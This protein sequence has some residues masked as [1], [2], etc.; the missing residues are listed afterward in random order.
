MNFTPELTALQ[1]VMISADN[2]NSFSKLTAK[3]GNEDEIEEVVLCVKNFL[4]KEKAPMLAMIAQV[5]EVVRWKIHT[6][7]TLGPSCLELAIKLQKL[8]MDTYKN[9]IPEK[10]SS[11]LKSKLKDR[12]PLNM[13]YYRTLWN[14][15]GETYFE[16]LTGIPMQ[17]EILVDKLAFH[18]SQ[19]LPSTILD[20]WYQLW[21]S[22]GLDNDAK[23]NIFHGALF[24]ISAAEKDN[25]TVITWA[26][27]LHCYRN[28]ILLTRHK[29][30]AEPLSNNQVS[31]M[32]NKIAVVAN[33]L[34][35][36]CIEEFQLL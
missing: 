32:I 18:L 16:I 12:N 36:G 10:E 34:E 25:R 20:E 26:C 14:P 21:E 31:T 23:L 11:W 35:E 33:S 22:F 27:L 6:F 5:L 30:V 29:Y 28:F 7:N 3:G 1:G 9:C 17:E 19:I 4:V 13:Y 15:S 2:V 8:V 24:L